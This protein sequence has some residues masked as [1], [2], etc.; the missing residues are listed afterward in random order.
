MRID[1]TDAEAP[2]LP[3][4]KQSHNL[5]MGRANGGRERFEIAQNTR[6]ILQIAT[7]QLTYDERMHYDQGFVE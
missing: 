5:L 1:P 2:K 7:C 4:F 6:S 3:D